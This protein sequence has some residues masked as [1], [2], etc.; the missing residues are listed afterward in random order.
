MTGTIE[1]HKI[2]VGSAKLFEG[3]SVDP[4]TLL[5]C[6]DELRQKGQTVMARSG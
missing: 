5:K 2:A 6:A 4:Q 3:L 1:E